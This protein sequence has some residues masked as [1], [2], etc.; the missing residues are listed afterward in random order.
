EDVL[1]QRQADA[2]DASWSHVSGSRVNF[3]GPQP[4]LAPGPQSGPSARPAARHRAPGPGSPGETGPDSVPQSPPV[5]VPRPGPASGPT[6]RPSRARE[7]YLGNPYALLSVQGVNVV[8]VD[9][10]TSGL[11]NPAAAYAVS[12]L[13]GFLGL[14]CVRRSRIDRGAARAAWLSLAAISV[15]ATGIWAMHFIAMLGFSIPGQTITYTVPITI[16]SM[17]LS[18]LVCG[19]GLFIVGYGN[20]GRGRLLTGGVILGVGVN[21]MHYMGMAGMSMPDTMSYNPLLVAASVVIAVVAGTAALWLGERVNTIRDTTWAAL[22][23]GVAVTGMHYTGMSALRVH[24]GSTDMMT[25]GASGVAF[26]LPVIVGLVVVTFG[27]TMALLLSRSDAEV[28]E[29]RR[30]DQRMAELIAKGWSEK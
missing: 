15:G 8:A 1:L 21:V 14:R 9:N 4:R 29:D 5:S 7:Q 27:I 23:M 17:L 12:C 6:V 25:S 11:L 16:A 10:F 22:I 24:R 20:G 26:L 30:L 13:G 19:I 18:I 28:V 3:T 2:I